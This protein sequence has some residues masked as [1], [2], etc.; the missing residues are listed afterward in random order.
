MEAITPRVATLDRADLEEL[1]Q[2]EIGSNG[3]NFKIVSSVTKIHL[4]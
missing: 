4:N 3:D 2:I 1:D